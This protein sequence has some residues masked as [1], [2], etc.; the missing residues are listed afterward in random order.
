MSIAI[1]VKTLQAF[2]PLLAEELRQLG[3]QNVEEGRRLVRGEVD[4]ATLYR[5]NY[6]SRL[7]LR[8]LCPIQNYSIRNADDLYFQALEFPWEDYLT[9]TTTFAIDPQVYSDLFPHTHYP[10][11]RL[12]DAIADRLRK[13][14]GTRP[15][16]DPK[17]PDVQFHLL[18]ENERVQ[19]S[20]DSSGRSLNQRG[21]RVK[22]GEAP[23]NEVLAAGMVAL[24]NWQGEGPLYNPFCGSGTLAI[25]AGYRAWNIPAQLLNPNFNFQT[26]RNFNMDLWEE[27]QDEENGKMKEGEFEIIASDIDADQLSIAKRNARDVPFFK[28]IQFKLVDFFAAKEEVNVPGMILMNPPYGERMEVQALDEIYSQLGSVFKHYYSGSEVWLISSDLTALNAV[29]L[30]PKK[31]VKAMNGKLECEIRGIELFRGKKSEFKKGQE[32]TD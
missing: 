20:L 12:K 3:V 18:I 5:V 9:P 10:S 19:I 28:H 4:E 24:A 1:V 2:E 30:K 6:S 13:Q 32:S 15:D 23:M 17:N 29:G 7:A 31:K 14:L 21:Y 25:E 27:I 11:M 26:W 8:V 16:V 22:G